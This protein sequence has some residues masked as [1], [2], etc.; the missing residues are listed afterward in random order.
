MIKQ[1][2]NFHSSERLS[3]IYSKPHDH[4]IYGRG[5]HTRVEITK[6]VLAEV[7]NRTKSS[8]VGDL[9]CG[10]GA[11]AKSLN[12]SHT[13]LGDYA[14]GYDYFGPIDKT[15][16]NMPKVSLYICS[17][18]L[19]HLEDPATVLKLIRNKS[20]HMILSTPIENWE[21]TNEEH[22][23]SWDRDGVESLL[24]ESGWSVDSFLMLDTTTFGEPYKY[25]I[26][27]CK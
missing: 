24:V 9:S 1:L 26:W 19:E 20:D 4:S 15:I 14:P 10:N 12:F 27:G 11:I 18:S 5:H 21:D 7:A 2:R 3:Q 25:G 17:E 13:Y 22:Y 23:W 8:S 16:L 6:V